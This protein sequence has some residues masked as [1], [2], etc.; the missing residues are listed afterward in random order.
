TFTTSGKT[1]SG[2]HAPRADHPHTECADLIGRWTSPPGANDTGLQS[3]RHTPCA[4]RPHTE[5]A[6]YIGRRTLPPCT[7]DAGLQSSR[8]TPCS[9][10]PHTECADYTKDIDMNHDFLPSINRR[11]FLREAG[12][13]LGGVAL[14]ALL[15][16]DA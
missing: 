5:C 2:R 6:D 9:D 10:R 3:S 1:Q 4:D 11:L 8:H 16:R 7:N 15:N 13:G 14:S 12:L